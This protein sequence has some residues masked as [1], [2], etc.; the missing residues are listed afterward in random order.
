MNAVQKMTRE[1]QNESHSAKAVMTWVSRELSRIA[2]Q[3]EQFPIVDGH[4]YSLEEITAL[5][6]IDASRQTLMDL[7]QVV[8]ALKPLMEDKRIDEG[9]LCSRITLEN[10]LHHIEELG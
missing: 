3:I 5:Q 2:A 8:L 4:A 6:A 10:T 7:H 9:E 1:T